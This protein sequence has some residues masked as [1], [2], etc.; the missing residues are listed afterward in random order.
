MKGQ[1]SCGSQDHTKLLLW[2][3]KWNLLGPSEGGTTASTVL[4]LPA[5]CHSVHR[6]DASRGCSNKTCLGGGCY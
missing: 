1:L 5:E 2:A 3:D 6:L 4:P